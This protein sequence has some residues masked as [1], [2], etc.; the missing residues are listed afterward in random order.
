MCYFCEVNIHEKYIFRCIQL[1][2]NGLGTSYPNPLVGSV[3]VYEERIIG[4]GWHA[5]AGGPHAEV[6]AIESVVDKSL[7]KTATLYVNLE[8]CSHFGKTPPCADLILEYG[9]P[10]VVIGTMDSNS[11]VCGRGIKR[12]R[13]AGCE[14]VVGVLK[15]ECY[16]LNRRF[17]TYHTKN[18]PYIFLKW[19]ETKDGFIDV[20]RT[21]NGSRGPN[22]ISNLYSQQLAH[23]LR[24]KEGAIMIGTKTALN[25]QP[26]LNAR[27]W[28]GNNPLRILLDKELKVPLKDAIFKGDQE[29]LVLTALPDTRVHDGHVQYAQIDFSK[30]LARQVCDLLFLKNIQSLIVEG[31]AQTLSTFIKANLWDEAHIFTGRVS[32]GKGLNAPEIKKVPV[33]TKKVHTDTLKIYRNS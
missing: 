9:I 31:G 7:L 2:K 26:S 23:K 19:A 27:K 3:I 11:K 6:R 12:L 10:K 14:V 13:E 20:E 32:F 5:C 24:A 16:E 29:T 33:I 4:E 21:A 28:S 15:Q 30:N 17:F 18:R 22:W 8:P 1:A 25:D